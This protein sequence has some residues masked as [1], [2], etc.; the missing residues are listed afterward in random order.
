MLTHLRNQ[1]VRVVKALVRP[2]AEHHHVVVLPLLISCER[3]GVAVRS[4]L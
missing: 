2:E 1:K 3:D 4:F